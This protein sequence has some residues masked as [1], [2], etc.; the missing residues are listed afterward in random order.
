[1]ISKIFSKAGVGKASLIIIVLTFIGNI[2]GLLRDR[3]LAHF[4]GAGVLSDAYYFSFTIPD[5]ILNI[6]VMGALGGIFIPIFIDSLHKSDEDARILGNTFLLII[7]VV[8]TLV[9]LLCFI[10]V[11]E[12][13]RTFTSG[14]Q[15]WSAQEFETAVMLFRIMLLYPLIVGVSNTIGCILNAYH[16][17]FSYA[18]STALYNIGITLSLLLLYPLM[19]IYAS[20]VGVLIGF[21]MHLGVRLLELKYTPFRFGGSLNFKHSGLK[22]IFWLMPQRIVTLLSFYGVI[23]GF[24]IIALHMQEGANTIRT[25][26]WNF[27][28]V[29]INLFAISIATAALP[30]LSKYITQGELGKF[31]E[32]YSRM[33]SQILFFAIPSTV[34]MIL[35]STPIIGVVLGTGKFGTDSIAMTALSLSIF[36]L[37]IPFESVNHLYVRM[38]Y[39]MKKVFIPTIA[40][41]LFAVATLSFTIFYGDTFGYLVFPI[42]W[43]IGAATQLLF[44]VIIYHIQHSLQGTLWGKLGIECL[45][46][47]IA[48]ATMATFLIA[49]SFLHLHHLYTVLLSV[50]VGGAV[51]L[52]ASLLMRTE[53]ASYAGDF[54]KKKFI[55]VEKSGHG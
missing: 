24:S 27:Q 46:I 44:S 2:L 38:F 30:L 50:I 53:T 51:F 35:L 25:Y 55:P 21:L 52:G 23:M 45:K 41:V 12:I 10:F 19:G 18:I 11:P 31:K 48:T 32:V 15:V 7:T 26:A 39:A 6:F 13:L 17:F 22:K 4:L 49:I 5:I 33:L 29:P 47:S 43:V 36:S 8:V 14:S 37:S 1:M 9:C 42:A 28:S 54:F 20:A 3:T 40:S 16:H 34:G